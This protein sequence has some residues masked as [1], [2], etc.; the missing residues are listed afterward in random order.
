MTC[1]ITNGE[2]LNA[3]GGSQFSYDLLPETNFKLLFPKASFG[4]LFLQEFNL[5]QVSVK[6]VNQPTIFADI[7]NVGEKISY[8]NMTLTFL[9]DK[10]M[11]NYK[12]IFNWMR[13]MTVSGSSVGDSDNPLLVINND[14]MIR[15]VEAWPAVLSDLTFRTNVNEV[16]YLT[17]TAVFN[18]DYFEFVGEEF[19]LQASSIEKKRFS[20]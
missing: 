3:D 14:N 8:G 13:R 6:D 4:T 19:H 20:K 2:L 7:N 10:H 11:K 17:C 18:F 15:F 5:P 16:N 12:E 9:V 1:K